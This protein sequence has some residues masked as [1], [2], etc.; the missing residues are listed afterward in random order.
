VKDMFKYTLDNKRYHTLNYYYKNKYGKKV[1]KV[2]LNAGFSC[3]NKV[4]GHGCI[5]CSRLG[6]GDFAGNK[7]DDLETQFYDV[8]KI[9][10]NK[11]NDAYYIGYF[12]ANTNTYAPLDV[13]KDKYEQVLQIPNVIGL[14]IATRP[15]AITDECYDYLEELNKRT[16]L[17]IEI[18]LQSIHEDTLKLINRG[19]DL[20]CFDKCIKELKKRNIKTVV[21]II[22]GLPYE[23]KEDML[24]TVKHLNELGIDGIKIHMLHIIKDTDLA[25]M[26]K[27]K[28]FHVLTKDEYIDIVINQLELLDPKIVI[29]RITG[30]PKKEDLIEPQWLLR[31]VALLD[32]IDKEM[33][34]R[35]VYQ[36]DK[37][38]E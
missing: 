10:K 15:D 23:T 14:N 22:N 26:Y 31:K 27:D 11:W 12:Q 24:E 34:R 25:D 35:D 20:A 36:G 33:V 8:L 21:H 17:T 5:F 13:L 30:D 18:G 4:D 3:P 37:I 9:M 1:F 6:S 7:E 19:H 2:A 29:N 38:K 28:P 16:D 32:D